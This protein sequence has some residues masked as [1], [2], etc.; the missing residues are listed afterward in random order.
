MYFF[1]YM[2]LGSFISVFPT[3]CTRTRLC[4]SLC[5]WTP[6]PPQP[7]L[8]CSWMERTNAWRQH[9][10]A[11]FTRSVVLCDQSMSWPAPNGYLG[12][13]D[14]TSTS[15]TGPCVASWSGCLRSTAWVFCSAPAPTPC[16]VRGGGKPLCPPAPTRRWR[17]CNLTAYT[18]RASVAEM[19]FAG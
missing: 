10:T 15:A 19:T 4:V 7:Q 8:S 16:V 6:P 12:P 1:Y 9:R 18:S 3:L 17:V 14:A 13:T 11:A 5:N 2:K